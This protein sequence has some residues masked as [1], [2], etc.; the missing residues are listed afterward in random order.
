MNR[1]LLLG[2][3]ANERDLLHTVHAARQRGFPVADVY[4]P[5]PVHGM[6]EA[7]GLKPSRLSIFCF[8]CGLLG[9]VLAMT[10]QH[11]TMAID[12]PINVGGRPFNSWPAFVPVGF[13]VMGLLGGFG[14]V[15]VVFGVSARFSRWADCS[16]AKRR[17]SSGRASPSISLCSWL[18]RKMPPMMTRPSCGSSAN[19][20][21]SIRRR[22][23]R[24]SDLALLR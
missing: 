18:R 23:M 19:T 12:W 3:F 10:M 4:T 14:V 21:R 8:V 5:Y 1:R 7:M 9:G 13:E 17:T 6:D 22:A 15:L 11:W 16:Q 24:T 20:T 2:T